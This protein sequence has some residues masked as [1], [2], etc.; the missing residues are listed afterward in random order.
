MGSTL[1]AALLLGVGALC[2]VRYH[3]RIEKLR[4]S[5]N[6]KAWRSELAKEGLLVQH[7]DIQYDCVPGSTTRFLV[8]GEGSYGKVGHDWDRR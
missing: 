4:V 6:I 7:G 5:E 8:L 2:Y 1:A 3:R